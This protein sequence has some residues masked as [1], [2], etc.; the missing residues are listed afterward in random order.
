[1]TGSLYR[2][3]GWFSLSEPLGHSVATVIRNVRMLSR[4]TGLFR[5][6]QARCDRSCRGTRPV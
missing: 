6:A 2:G 3:A 1:L 4:W 5:S